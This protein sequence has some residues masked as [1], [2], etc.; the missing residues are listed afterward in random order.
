MTSSPALI[1]LSKQD[2]TALASVGECVAGACRLHAEGR[3]FAAIAIREDIDLQ[4]GE[5]Q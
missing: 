4:Q 2:L 5:A 1:V 3:G